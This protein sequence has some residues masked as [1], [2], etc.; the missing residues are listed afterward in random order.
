[1]TGQS[2]ILCP[3][4]GPGRRSRRDRVQFRPGAADRGPM[5]MQYPQ[6]TPTLPAAGVP[7]TR[8]SDADRDAAAALLGGAFAEGRLT[9]D[10]HG[11]R[12][13]AAYAARGWQQL[14]PLT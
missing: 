6:A 7:Q 10:E 8:A 14:R 3:D 9:A 11:E 12:L 2:V 5:S 13:N 1:M 4:L